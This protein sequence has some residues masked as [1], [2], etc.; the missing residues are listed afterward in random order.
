MVPAVGCAGID[1][2][3]LRGLRGERAILGGG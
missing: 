1:L 2:G 3:I